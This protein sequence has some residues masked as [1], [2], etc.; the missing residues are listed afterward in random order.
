[1]E[2]SLKLS[3]RSV[4]LAGKKSIR[5]FFIVFM[6]TL[7]L[8]DIFMSFASV[9]GYYGELVVYVPYLF[10]AIFWMMISSFKIQV[11]DQIIYEISKPQIHLF[12]LGIPQDVPSIG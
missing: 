1:M 11:T 4:T 12:G 10:F 7:M 2:A 3:M 5:L 6:G 8:V 9:Y